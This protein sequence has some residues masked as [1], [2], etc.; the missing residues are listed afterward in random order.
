MVNLEL[1]K[2][3]KKIGN[4]HNCKSNDL[5]TSENI[6]EYK[7]RGVKLQMDKEEIIKCKDCKEILWGKIKTLR[8]VM[9]NGNER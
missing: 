8:S 6:L 1:D 5:E 4:C 9:R 3:L 2:R 7:R